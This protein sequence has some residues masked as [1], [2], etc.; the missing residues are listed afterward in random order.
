MKNI[1]LDLSL[2]PMFFCCFY[3]SLSSHVNREKRVWVCSYYIF[4]SFFGI[5]VES[6]WFRISWISRLV[7]VFFFFLR[8]AFCN[9]SGV[10]E[11]QPFDN[12][13]LDGT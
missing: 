11:G 6:I 1:A 3:F 8:F 10:W 13:Y 5:A 4:V 7:D 12:V 2:I 9:W